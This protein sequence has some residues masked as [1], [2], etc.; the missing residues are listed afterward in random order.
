MLPEP[1]VEDV[2]DVLRTV[3]R[4]LRVDRGQRLGFRG[5]GDPGQQRRPRADALCL[6]S[7]PRPT[8]AWSW[9]RSIPRPANRLANPCQNWS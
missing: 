1:K 9:G 5:H 2:L 4:D 8:S 3:R 6:S 7:W